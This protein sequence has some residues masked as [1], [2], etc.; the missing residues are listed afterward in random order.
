MWQGNLI[1]QKH[2]VA[3]K[4]YAAVSDRHT[5]FHLLHRPDRARVQQRMV[6][7]ETG[8]PVSADETR[9]AYEIEAG[10][11]VVLSSEELEEIVPKASRDIRIDRFVPELAIEPQSFD[12]PYF[13]GPTG[14]SHADYFA[15]AEAIQ[16]KKS[17]GVA[18][19]VMRNHSYVGAVIAQQGYLMLITLRHAGEVIPVTELDPP[20]GRPLA[21]QERELADQLIEAL[22][23]DFQSEAYHDEYQERVRELIDAK[24][25]GKKLKP[26]RVPRRPRQESLV[27]SLR[28]SL[29]GAKTRRSA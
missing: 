5:H 12:R 3:V 17:A 29:K 22:S 25:A 16:S 8:E 6:D 13:L 4:L 20:K 10:V 28:A 24:Q 18:T 1:I 9:K 7:V 2:Q 11:Y 19:W 14:D 21:S 26:K 23:G 27:D 15:L